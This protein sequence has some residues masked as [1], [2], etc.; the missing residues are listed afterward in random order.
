MIHW[1]DQGPVSGLV[2]IEP[3]TFPLCPECPLSLTLSDMGL[4]M[5]AS[6]MKEPPL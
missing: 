4:V 1:D 3:L 2:Q 5:R 6:L